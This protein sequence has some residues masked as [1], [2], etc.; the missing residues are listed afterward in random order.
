MVIHKKC[1]GCD[2]IGHEPDMIER[3][4][5]DWTD[6][7]CKECYK[8]IYKVTECPCGHGYIRKEK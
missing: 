3:V 6:Y 1:A 2:K 5:Y 8:L 4:K 7:Y